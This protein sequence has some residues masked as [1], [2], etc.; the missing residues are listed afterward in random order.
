[1]TQLRAYLEEYLT[2]I[3]TI[4]H[5][6]SDDKGLKQAALNAWPDKTDPRPLI[7]LKGGLR[8]TTNPSTDASGGDDARLVNEMPQSATTGTTSD[9]RLMLEQYVNAISMILQTCKEDSEMIIKAESRWP[10]KDDPRRL[11]FTH[12]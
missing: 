12:F 7:F 9:L 8:F 10:K 1:M 4:L 11:V 2:T 3:N 6:D 5:T